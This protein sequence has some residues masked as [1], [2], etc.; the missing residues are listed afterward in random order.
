MIVLVEVALRD[1]DVGW[2]G[3]WSMHGESG[4][5][6]HGAVELV[7]CVGRVVSPGRSVHWGKGG[8]GIGFEL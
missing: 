6:L 8:G 5:A 1:G 7:R 4:A 3:S 2:C